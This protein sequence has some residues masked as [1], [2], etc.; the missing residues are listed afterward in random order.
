MALPNETTSIE[1][2]DDLTEQEKEQ[3]LIVMRRAKVVF[4]TFVIQF[5]HII[6]LLFF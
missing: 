6:L 2:I 5:L 1:G 4:K 3:L